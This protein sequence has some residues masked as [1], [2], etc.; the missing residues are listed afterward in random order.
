MLLFT[1]AQVFFSLDRGGERTNI[2]W[3]EEN[4]QTDNTISTQVDNSTKNKAEL[5]SILVQYE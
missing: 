2:E 4:V 1:N 3:T 5:E